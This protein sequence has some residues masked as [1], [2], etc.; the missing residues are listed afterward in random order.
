MNAPL[1]TPR[2][3]L[4]PETWPEV[5]RKAW[6]ALFVEIDLFD[7]RSPAAHWSEGSR[8][9]REQ[10]YGH[11]LGFLD[12]TGRLEPTA[13]P[14][15]RISPEAVRAYV[16]EEDARC[17]PTTVYIHVEDLHAVANALDPEADWR[18]LHT[19]MTR[20]RWRL[21]HNTL[22]PRASV[23]ARFLLDWALRRM[24]EADADEDLDPLRRAIRYRQALMIGVLIARPFRIRAFI[25]MEV[26]EHLAASEHGYLMRFPA[27]LM[28]DRKA[29]EHP[30]TES[31]VEPMRRYL[32]VH[33]PCL[34]QGG[35]R[36]GLWITQYGEVMTRDGFTRELGKITLREFGET[37]R[38]HAF[39]HIAATS[40]ATD[41]PEHVGIIADV[42]GHASSQM[43]EKHYNRARGVEA[44]ASYQSLME[45]LRKQ[46]KRRFRRG[47][48]GVQS[49]HPSAG[50]EASN[51]ED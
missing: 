9:K 28:K 50:K 37:L 32:E 45:D 38:P 44:L 33:R 41:D 51:A 47:R 10:G 5:D 21:D 49:G 17:A 2:L 12:R 22:K 43:A 15:G 30:L 25:A 24:R 31:L 1:K 39:R 23:D 14:A 42:L 34:L 13:D 6:Q 19:L 27:E 26:D 40:I 7:G 8:R 46:A 29:R 4:K 3:I 16:A 18:W 20:L 11:W 35:E 36:A 48:R